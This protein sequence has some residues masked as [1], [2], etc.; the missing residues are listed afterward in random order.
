MS[1]ESTD[2]NFTQACQYLEL[3]SDEFTELR[4]Q[5]LVASLNQSGRQAYP[6]QA[7]ELTRQLLR[8]GQIHGWGIPTLAWYADLV[9]ATEVGRAILLPIVDKEMPAY[10]LPTSWLETP[11]VSAV[12]QDLESLLEDRESP[13]I[14]LLR[15]IAAIAVGEE[16]VWVDETDLRSSSLYPI[17]SYFEAA[18][19]PMLNQRQT[20][21]R[22][23]GLILQSMLHTFITI[24]PP[25][26]P[27]LLRLISH[28][29]GKLKGQSI[30]TSSSPEERTKIISENM[31]A[32]DR[33]YASKAPEIHT[34]P[35]SWDLR[36]GAMVAQKQTIAL[37]LKLP[38]DPEQVFID[39]IIDLIRPYVGPYGARVVH[40]LYEIANDA[41]YWRN[42]Q[43][44]VDTNELLD[45][46]GLKR[47]K[48]GYHQAKNRERLRNALNIAH[49]LEVVGEYTSWENRHPVRKALRKTVL[50]LIGASYDPEET[51]NLSTSELFQRGLPK[52]MQVKL[53]FYEGVRQ[54]DGRLGT[55]YVLTPRLAEPSKLPKA[56]HAAT[57]ELLRAYLLLR[58]RQ[59]RMVSRTI[60]VVRE[61]ALE[62]ANINTKNVTRA[63]Q[64]LTRALEKLVAE[65]TVSQFTKVPLKA[66]E[67]FEVILSERATSIE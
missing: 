10:A 45:R 66:N 51:K 34:P 18:E 3:T 59:T 17:I 23:I 48:H 28:V 42:P 46:L 38:L 20:I 15:S 29:Q 53:N 36:L 55:H 11:Y 56:N 21:A 25:I 62:K 40:L 33:I 64:I 52:T 65:G 43:I 12:L 8:L 58:Y 47:S 5:G 26:S 50:S 67:S 27:D 2:L 4:R 37:Q 1:E 54:L 7:L 13:L 22:D 61:T 49:N 14:N 63:T 31:I 39:N 35:E 24:A 19:V 9:F 41:P 57:H 60:G 44:T 16:Q 32:V 30:G 6:Q